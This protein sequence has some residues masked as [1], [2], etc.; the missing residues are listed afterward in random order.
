MD[1][2]IHGGGGQAGD[3]EETD[4]EGEVRSGMSQSSSR[5]RKDKN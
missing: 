5:A 4:I 2:Q 1:E 3:G